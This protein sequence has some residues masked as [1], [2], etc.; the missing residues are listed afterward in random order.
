MIETLRTP[1]L[2]VI[3]ATVAVSLP[4][5]PFTAGS[6][7]REFYVAEPN[8]SY[9]ECRNCDTLGEALRAWIELGTERAEVSAY[10][11]FADEQNEDF[12]RVEKCRWLAE[13]GRWSDWT[14]G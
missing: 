14:A 2:P 8:K 13:S 6:I 3:P 9:P 10:Q 5:P 1:T 12:K 4:E 7:E 11:G